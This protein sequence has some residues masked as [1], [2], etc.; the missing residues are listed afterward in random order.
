MTG[1]HAQSDVEHDLTNLKEIGQTALQKSVENQTGKTSTVS[2]KT[3][4]TQNKS[5]KSAN[6]LQTPGKSDEVTA[7]LR[8]TQVIASGGTIDIKQ[9]IGNHECS[10]VPPSLFE[11]DGT[12]RSTGSKANLIKTVVEETGISSSTVLPPT[13][14]KTAVVVDA[15]YMI[16]RL[17]FEKDETF[18]TIADRY[19]QSLL[20]SVPKETSIIHFCCDRYRTPSTKASE[21]QKRAKQSRHLKVYEVTDQYKAPDPTDF[22]ANTANKARLLS[23]FCNKWCTDETER[24]CPSSVPLYLGGGFEDETKIRTLGRGHR[25]FYNRVRIQS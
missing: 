2:L 10:N 17:S 18:D 4:H 8:M 7:L 19:R 21:R 22:F 23:Y 1:Q 12:M 24:T 14:R 25:D 16:H 20:N 3:F 5:S 9:Y 15:M 11:E 6:K 13:D